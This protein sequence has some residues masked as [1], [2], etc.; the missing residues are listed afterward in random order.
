MSILMLIFN[1]LHF[2]M[3]FYNSEAYMFLMKLFLEVTSESEAK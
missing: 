3:Y 2:R 1:Y